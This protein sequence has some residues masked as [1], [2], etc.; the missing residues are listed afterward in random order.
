MALKEN[1]RKIFHQKAI[2]TNVS[3]LIPLCLFQAQSSSQGSF[4][5]E[6]RKLVFVTEDVA[7][8]Y[9][10]GCDAISVFNI[11]KEEPVF[12]GK[13]IVSPGRLAASDDLTTIIATSSNGFPY[14]LAPLPYSDASFL[15]ILRKNDPLDDLSSWQT[16]VITAPPQFLRNGA[17]ALDQDTLLLSV[18]TPPEPRALNISPPASTE[19]HRAPYEIQ[20]YNLSEITYTDSYQG[21]LG[22]VHGRFLLDKSEPG[23][24]H[25]AND[26][27][28]GG[29]EKV[30]HI[31]S[32]DGTIR[33][34]YLDSME[35]KSPLVRI[36]PQSKTVDSKLSVAHSTISPNGRFIVTNRFEEPELNVADLVDRSTRSIRLSNLSQRDSPKAHILGVAFNRG[37]ENQGLFAI[38]TL[39]MVVVYLFDGRG[40]P[41]ELSRIKFNEIPQDLQPFY[42]D[43][44]IDTSIG[45]AGPLGKIAWSGSGSDII[46]SLT[47][48]Y[49]GASEF[50]VLKTDCSGRITPQFNW[51]AC[52]KDTLNMPED[53]FT[54]NGKIT[55]E[56]GEPTSSCWPEATQTPEST[57][58]PTLSTNTPVSTITA[59]ETTIDTATF[60][61]SPASETRPTQSAT[62]SKRSFSYLPQVKVRDGNSDDF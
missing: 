23:A 38:N 57:P 49:R 13:R 10:A 39:N 33:S 42:G 1:F 18:G 55:P 22:E 31:V 4:E 43:Y 46:A 56:A 15:Y 29:S 27:T 19:P 14:G 58:T 34:I 60:T 62:Y 9:R 54:A 61:A 21:R 12:R 48:P 3:L 28:S 6:M 59:R 16:H 26:M 36:E 50:R 35:E 11:E 8:D 17:I 37:F 44:L 52:P 45:S 32:T 25:I 24:I 2:F 40:E 30:A 5:D 20:K 53:I 7:V 51:V 47:H 41:S